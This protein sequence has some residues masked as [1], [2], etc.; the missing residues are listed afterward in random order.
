ME[1]YLMAP[2]ISAWVFF[3]ALSNGVVR[4]CYLFNFTHF[5]KLSPK[6][7]QIL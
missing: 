2:K 6:L 4:F 1:I 5:S 3:D 7:N